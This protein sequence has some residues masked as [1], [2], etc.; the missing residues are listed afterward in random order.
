MHRA[1]REQREAREVHPAPQSLGDVRPGQRG[2]LD[3][4]EQVERHDAPRHRDGVPGPRERNQHVH[5][6]EVDVGIG[7]DGR[8]VDPREHQGHAAQEAMEVE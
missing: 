8:H 3:G 4:Q 1:R 7:E 6:A 2:D 5:Q